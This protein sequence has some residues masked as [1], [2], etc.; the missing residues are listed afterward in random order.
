M[1]PRGVHRDRREQHV[2]R[3]G[4]RAADGVL[5]HGAR[6]QLLE[7]TAAVGA[8]SSGLR[9]GFLGAGV[10]AHRER[11]YR[12]DRRPV[13]GRPGARHVRSA[14][15]TAATQGDTVDD[16]DHHQR[17]H[18]RRHRAGGLRRRHRRRG[19][20]ITE[21]AEKGSLQ[22]P[23]RRVIEREGH[24]VTPGFVDIHTHFD[25]QVCWDKLVTPSS[26]HGV[27]TV[28][29]GQ[30]RRRLRAVRPGQEDA[31]VQLMESVEDIPGH[32]AARG[33]AVGMGELRRLPRR[34]RHALRHGHRARRLPH[35]AVR[36]YVMGG[37]LRRGATAEDIAAMAAIHHG[38]PSP[39]A[40]WAFD[41]ALLR[42][43]RQERPGRPRHARVGGRDDG[44][45]RGVRRLRH[46]TLEIFSDHLNDPDE[47]AWMA[48]IARVSGRPLTT[49]VTA[50]TNTAVWGL[51]DE[52]RAE[53]SSCGPR[54]ARPASVLM[55]LDGTLNPMRQF[56]PTA[57]F[58][59]L[60]SRSSRA[61]A[62]SRL[63]GRVLADSTTSSRSADANAM[64]R[65]G[66]ACT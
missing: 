42:A 5:D 3:L 31:L 11:P 64:V 20:R 26:W 53:G 14:R 41:V 40:R 9:T 32:S 55:S 35:V 28:V 50:G 39:T 8:G 62:R 44:D 43:R 21:V 45:R 49:L 61:S 18:R 30:L 22:R 46:G 47:L 48:H 63:P 60:R 59:R 10:R 51:A 13:L 54:S 58:Q 27:T 17:P 57:R 52:L 34:H 25:G 1:E 65:R 24:L 56:T 6:R 16:L 66:T 36:L 23:A 19:G 33:H 37:A 29:N 15:A 2:V 7:P 38:R 12:D 4:D